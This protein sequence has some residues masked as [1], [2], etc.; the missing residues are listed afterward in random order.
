[1]SEIQ[2]LQSGGRYVAYRVEGAGPIDLLLCDEITMVSIDST[3]DEPHR[4]H[5]DERLASFA[6]LITFDRGGI[7]LSDPPPAGTPLSVEG[8]ADDALSVLDAAGSKQAAVFG[9]C[10]GGIPLSLVAR[11]PGRV[12]HLV[13]FNGYATSERASA[14]PWIRD[15]EGWIDATTRAERDAEVVDDVAYLLPSLADDASFRRWWRQ[16]GQRGASPKM[17]SAHN[18]VILDLDLR[19]VLPTIEVPTLVLYR[20]NAGFASRATSQ[21][22]AQEVPGARVVELPG[23]DYFPFAG[24]ADAVADEIEEFLTGS[25]SPRAVPRVLTT[26]FFSDIVGSTVQATRLGDHEW[27]TRLDRHDAALRRQFQRFG[28]REVNTTGDGFIASFDVPARAV[29]CGLAACGAAREAGVEIRVGIHTGEV[30]QRGDDLGGI[31][32]HIAARI[33]AAADPSS[34]FV[35]STV[36]D[37]VT[38]SELRFRDRGPHELKGVPGSW[39]L[40]EAVA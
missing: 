1:V 23:A 29:Q 37:L 31:G 8:W 4:H 27:R 39:Q 9:M 25:N 35:S 16:A 20:T 40:F 26:I 7:G 14:Q 15:Y 12:S 21:K 30:E 24:D 6:R 36:K 28:G 13:L 33:L 32:V 22:L 34:V 17:A 18:R 10:S 19:H 3:A 38:G 2:Y 11:A 5:F